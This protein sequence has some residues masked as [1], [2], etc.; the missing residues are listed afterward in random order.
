MCHWHTKPCNLSRQQFSVC[1]CELARHNEWLYDL[2][3]DISQYIFLSS[4]KQIQWELGTVMHSSLGW[5]MKIAAHF[6]W[7]ATFD[8]HIQFATFCTSCFIV[9]THFCRWISLQKRSQ[10]S[11]NLCI[12]FTHSDYHRNERHL[13]Y[14]FWQCIF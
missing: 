5:V 14:T 8:W 1:M 4:F 12:L 9:S 11:W 7:S 3:A 2:S 6:G 13:I 10:A